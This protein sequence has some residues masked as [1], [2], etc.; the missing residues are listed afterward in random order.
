MQINLR[1]ARGWATITTQK[2]TLSG[3]DYVIDVQSR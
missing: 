2:G 1:N 3:P